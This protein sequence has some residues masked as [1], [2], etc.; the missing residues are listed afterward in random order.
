[1]LLVVRLRRAALDDGWPVPLIPVDPDRARALGRLALLALAA[2]ER[3]GDLMLR[4]TDGGPHRSLADLGADPAMRAVPRGGVDVADPH[5]GALTADEL[6]AVVPAAPLRAREHRA[7]TLDD[8]DDAGWLARIDVH[9]PG[10]RGVLGLEHP[11]EG[12][13]S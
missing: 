1:E 13:S 8:A 5:T 9:G 7:L 2:R 4:P 10:L 11:F 3:P 12:A 6:R